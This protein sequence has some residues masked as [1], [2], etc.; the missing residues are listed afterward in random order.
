M[1]RGSPWAWINPAAQGRVLTILVVLTVMLS[2]VLWRVSEPLYTAAAPQGMVSYELAGSQAQASRI[3]ESWSARAR[4][5]AL[6]LQGLDYLYLVL[7]PAFLSLGCAHVARRLVRSASRL[8]A[9]GR[10]LS[11]AVLAA[12]LFDAVENYALIEQLLSAPTE[13]WAHVAWWCA[14]PKFTLVVLALGY[15]LAGYAMSRFQSHGQ[16]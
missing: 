4:E 16:R 2:I 9:L 7:Y 15:A 13:R 6:L 8:A 1:E 3:L 5:Q 11:W 14:V 12:G 10:G